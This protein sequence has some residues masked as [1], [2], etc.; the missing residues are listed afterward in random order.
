MIYI[1]RPGPK[2]SAGIGPVSLPV[3]RPSGQGLLVGSPAA[4]SQAASVLRRLDYRCTEIDDPYA[5]MSELA[6]QPAAY[7]SLVLSLG[8]FFPEELQV[9]AAVKRHFPKI[10]I[11]LIRGD[12][13][14]GAVDE[15][16]QLGADGVLTDDGLHR[17]AAPA[18]ITMATEAPV[19]KPAEASTQ[20]APS[21]NDAP[22]DFPPCDPILSAEELKAL[23]EEPP[24]ARPSGAI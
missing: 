3:A 19:E 15:A 12:G 11:W 16:M 13:L 21:D 1:M 2:T 8:S 9:V 10:E 14:N 24:P 18:T 5:A 22:A 7:T 6:R 20:P 23:L 4:R 17:I